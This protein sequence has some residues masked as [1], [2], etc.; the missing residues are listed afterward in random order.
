MRRW[1]KRSL[2]LSATGSL[3]VRLLSTRTDY[4]STENDA[5]DMLVDG[6]HRDTLRNTGSEFL[7]TPAKSLLMIPPYL[8]FLGDFPSIR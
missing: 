4:C 5:C 3:L 1:L 7:T 8:V 2:A 6:P